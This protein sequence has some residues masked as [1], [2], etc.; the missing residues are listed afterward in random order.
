MPELMSGEE[1]EDNEDNE[2]EEK[3]LED[4]IRGIKQSAA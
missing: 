1:D 4:T 2:L 3:R